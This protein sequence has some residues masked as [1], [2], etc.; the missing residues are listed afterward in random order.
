MSDTEAEGI[1]PIEDQPPGIEGQNELEGMI[2]PGDAPKGALDWGTT[3]REEQLDEPLRDR[4]RREQREGLRGPGQDVGRLVQPD[5]GMVG[6]DTEPTEI[7][8]ET[9]DDDALAAEEA[10]MH[11]ADTP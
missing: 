9:E 3:A 5:A 4:V 7:A 1:P 2:P 6:A 11:I 8:M 10:A